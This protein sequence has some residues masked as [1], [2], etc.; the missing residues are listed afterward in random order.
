MGSGWRLIGGLGAGAWKTSNAINR[1]LSGR[2]EAAVANRGLGAAR[3]G[4][5]GPGDADP[6][7]HAPDFF[8]YRG[9]ATLRSLSHLRGLPFTLG[10]VIDPRRGPAGQIGLDERFL[11]RHAAVIGPSGSGKTSSIIIPWIAAALQQGNSVVAVDVAGDLLEQVLDYRKVVGALGATVGMWDY[12]KPSTSVSWNWLADLNSEESVVSAVEALIGREN[13]N[14]PQPF[15]AQRDRRVLRGL[16]DAVCEISS[17]PSIDT[18]LLAA[19]DQPTLKRLVALAPKAKARLSEVEQMNAV[20]FGRAMSGI[21]NALDVFEHPNVRHVTARIQF[22]ARSLFDRPS[23]IVIGAPLH[24]SRTSVT[25]SSLMIS[26]ITRELYTRFGTTQGQQV[27]LFLDEAARLTDRINFEELL[28]VS[29][30]AGVSVVLA[31]QTVTQFRDENERSAILD[32][33]GTYISLPTP[34][35]ES[36]EYFISRLGQRQQSSM[37]VNR[38]IGSTFSSSSTQYSR[39]VASVPV[40][41]PREIMDPPWGGRPAVIHCVE[42]ASAPIL[43]DLSRDDLG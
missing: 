10:S 41:G 43:V 31:A 30:R 11:A 37:S 29:R 1:G 32:N 36:A 5:L 42:A 14:D 6:P 12:T 23:L 4:V 38:Q 9:A 3:S 7:P 33:C 17:N 40:I 24:G 13:P 2:V 35:K 26:Q 22:T 34:S 25:L 18:L 16:I 8:D 20:D 19:R 15:F 39:S 27:F 21:N 28:S